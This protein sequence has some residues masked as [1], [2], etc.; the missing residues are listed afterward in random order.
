MKVTTMGFYSKI[1]AHPILDMEMETSPL[2]IE[3]IQ[4]P[5]LDEDDEQAETSSETLLQMALVGEYQQWDL[6]V[7]YASRLKGLSRSPIADEFKSHAGEELGHIELL[8]RYL[9]SMGVNPTLQRK[10]SPELP[11]QATIKDIVQ[12]QL[13]FEQDA[14]NLYKKILNVLPEN[15]PLKLDIE[16][17]LI[18]EQ[19]HVHD[20]ELMLKSTVVAKTMIGANAK[21]AAK[22]LLD[23]YYEDKEVNA[24]KKIPAKGTPDWH[25]H[26]IALDTVKNPNKSLLSGPS[27]E[28]S[29]KMLKQHF[30]YSDKDL[31]E[32]TSYF[33]PMEPGEPTKPQAGYGQGCGC[34]NEG[35]QCPSSFLQKV[36]K[37]WCTQA[38]KE[39]TPDIYARWYQGKLLS[40]QEKAFVAQA[41]SLKWGLRDKRAMLRFLDSCKA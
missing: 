18:K 22:E 38:L 29:K 41:I 3:M 33:R 2:N 36:D 14:V 5:I 35:C 16:S 30:G 40:P 4:K 26:K 13:K 10:P 8:Q 7:A 32:V 20:L 28:E 6:Y 23:G 9:V 39:L 24:A 25:K 21:K 37:K 27:L 15:E 31:K 34:G 11:Q 1:K 12:L 19:E 17:V